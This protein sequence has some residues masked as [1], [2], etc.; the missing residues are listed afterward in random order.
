MKTLSDRTQ[1]LIA[2]FNLTQSQLAK[3]AGIK[4]PSVNRWLKGQTKTMDPDAALKISKKFSVSLQWLIDGTGEPVPNGVPVTVQMEEDKPENG[5]IEVKTYEIR[6]S[7]GFGC[8][9]SYEDAHDISS[10]SYPIS[11]F[12]VNHFNPEKIKVF[13]VEGDSMEP[14]LWHGDRITVN[15]ADKTIINGKVYAFVYQGE[16]RVK[17]LRKLLNGGI[18]VMSDN[19]SWDPETI[20]AD[21]LENMY[22]VGRVVDKSGSGGL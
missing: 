14:F 5:F 21:S 22:I 9:P 11:W 13:K 16:Y 17:R 8:E 4:Q 12:Q 1:W 6:C 19:P 3:I 15:T 20:S 18:V 10:R 2:K 7:A